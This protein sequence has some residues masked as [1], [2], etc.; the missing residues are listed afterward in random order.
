MI[1][2]KQ[3][4]FI[5][6]R[7]AG[8]STLTFKDPSNEYH[9]Y[10]FV[11]K[12]GTGK[13][14][15]LNSITW[16]L[17]QKEYLLKDEDTAL[18][19]IN[20]KKLN[21]M[22]NNETADV[23]VR[24]TLRDEDKNKELVFERS[25]K[26]MKVESNSGELKC[27]LS[28]DSN[29]VVT[30]S[31]LDNANATESHSGQ[32]ADFYVTEYFDNKIHDFFFFDG[33]KLDDFF[34]SKA[35]SIQSSVEA[36]AQIS[37]LDSSIK[38]AKE[39]ASSLRSKVSKNRPD[40]RKLE[41]DCKE[42]YNSIEKDKKNRDEYIAQKEQIQ[43]DKE[44]DEA[45]QREHA[46]SAELQRNKELLSDDLNTIKKQI[47]DLN[48]EKSAFAI[49]SVIL[50]KSYP[51][52]R[53]VL[54]YIDKKDASGDYSALL[55]KQQL[56]NILEEATAHIDNH[57]TPCP[58]CGTKFSM[59]QLLYLQDLIS[60]QTVDDETSITLSN[61]KADLEA[62]CNE[63]ISFREKYHE[64]ESKKIEL[65]D[66][67]DAVE[68]EYN[69]VSERLIK[70]GTAR[71]KDGNK[72][73]F[74]KL[75]TNIRNA[76]S[77]ISSLDQTI[78]SLSSV[79]KEK[80]NRYLSIKKDYEKGVKRENDDK[81]SQNVI[82]TLDRV[83]H[84]LSS[85]K[86]EITGEMR[87]KLVKITTEIFNGIINKKQTFGKIQMDERYR[88]S[89]YDEYGLLMTGS[90][91]ATEYMMLAYAY[92]LALHEASGHNCPLVIDTPLA[93]VSGENIESTANMLLETSKNKQIILLFTEKEFSNEV[94]KIFSGVVNVAT[95]KL[96]SHERAWEEAIV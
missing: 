7:I 41:T 44:A 13:T 86:D 47:D 75:E 31:E 61:L 45:L 66:K 39:T 12:N 18:P 19:I 29:F 68:R 78:G 27:V 33:D 2:I 24:L 70:L 30:I 90:S 83:I 38:N 20:A 3:I 10:C 36:I 34:V 42:L 60:H 62:A 65:Q 71:D 23:Q 53:K 55:T 40:L 72:I 1:S 25:Q 85:V 96:A 6:Y 26:I 11:A 80:E 94:E 35:N 69:K 81:D 48:K 21:D 56:K 14:T 82:D 50:I 9:M 58:I 79:I 92:T 59:Q 76:T 43:N 73:D 63:V 88:L 28:P 51:S 49:R 95:L 64:Y 54:A 22:E 52:I 84:N 15:I 17:Y 89:L 37:L 67:F 16:C 32:D 46:V 87:D 74:S 5:N 8:T 77:Q 4:D 93:R 57:P 91:S